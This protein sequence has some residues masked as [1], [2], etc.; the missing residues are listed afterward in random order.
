VHR[1][2]L[3]FSSRQ[4]TAFA[5]LLS[6]PLISVL[7]DEKPARDD[8]PKGASAAGAGDSA[9][10]LN[11]NGTVLLDKKGKRV[12]LKAQVALRQGALEMLCC[13]KQ[14][15]EHESILS[16]DARAQEVHAALLAIDARPGMPVQYNPEYQA[17]T[18]QKIEIFVN[19]TDETGKARRAAAQSWVRQAINRFWT[20]KMDALPKGLE[21]PKNTE[22]RYDRKLKELSW[23]GP[24]TAVQK[25]E[26]LALSDDKGYRSAIESFFEQ[27]QAKEMKA[28]WVFAGSGFYTDEETGKKSYLAEGGDLI[29]VANF[30]DATIDVAIPSSADDS[31][32]NFEAYTERIPPKDTPVTIELIPVPAGEKKDATPKK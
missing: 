17:P 32:R 2:S 3:I 7:A 8:A 9:V 15:K 4:F 27:S 14:T 6:L 21:L 28:D 29:C 5:V 24:M 18:G 22:L 1:Y 25:K 20:V 30:A 13:L 10:P 16:L 31:N 11:K 26:F 12:L 19:W 23:Y